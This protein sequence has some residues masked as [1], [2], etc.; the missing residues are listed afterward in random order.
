MGVTDGTLFVFETLTF[1]YSKSHFKMAKK[2][3]GKKKRSTSN[4]FSQFEQS[5]IQEFKEAFQMIDADRNGIITVGDL[6]ATYASLGV[7]DLDQDM[8]DNMCAEAGAPINFTIFLNIWPTNSTVPTQKTLLSKPSNSS[9]KTTK[10]SSQSRP[11]RKSSNPRPTDSTTTNS[12]NSSNWPSQT[13]KASLTTKP[14]A[15]P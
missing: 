4:V 8:L 2:A 9:T 7:R 6:K 1:T 11:S 10:V 14:S 5:Q 15:T 13:K 12:N 3:G